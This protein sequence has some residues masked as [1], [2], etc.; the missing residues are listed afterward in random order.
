MLIPTHK[1]ETG[2]T[3]AFTPGSDAEKNVHGWERAASIAGGFVLLSKGLRRGGIGGLLEVAMGGMGL[4]RGFTGR[5][6]AKKVLQAAKEDVH[7][8]KV[9]SG[10]KL[11]HLFENADAATRSATVTGN[12]SLSSPKAGV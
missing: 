6:A 2:A 5:C 1:D 11:D 4:V 7:D 8:F 9:A 10:G 3:S 12:E